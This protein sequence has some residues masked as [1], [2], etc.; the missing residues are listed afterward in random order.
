MSIATAASRVYPFHI[1]LPTDQT[2]LNFEAKSEA[3]QV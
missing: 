2:G 3:E 1:F